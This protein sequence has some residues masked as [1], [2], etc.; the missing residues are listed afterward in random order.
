[1]SAISIDES[2][3]SSRARLKCPSARRHTDWTALE[4]AFY[5]H[6]CDRQYRVLVDGKDGVYVRRDDVEIRARRWQRGR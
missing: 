5:C 6:T 1:M 4:D 3:W 2:D